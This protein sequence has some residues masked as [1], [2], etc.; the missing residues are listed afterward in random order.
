MVGAFHQSSKG[1]GLYTLITFV[2]H[3]SLASSTVQGSHRSSKAYG[4]HTFA[5]FVLLQYLKAPKHI[6][7][8]I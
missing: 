1:Y 2:S 7:G 5:T 8:S 6:P 3:L 4:L